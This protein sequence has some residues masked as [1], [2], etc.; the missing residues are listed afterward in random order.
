[1]KRLVRLEYFFVA[2]IRCIP[3]LWLWKYFYAKLDDETTSANDVCEAKPAKIQ[4]FW[5]FGTQIW[6]VQKS[7]VLFTK[8][9]FVEFTAIVKQETINAR[10]I[11]QMYQI[12]GMIG[13]LI[14]WKFYYLV[15]WKKGG[16]KNALFCKY[17]VK[18]VTV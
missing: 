4:L 6:S 3:P 1:M 9:K 17:L 7:L 11:F 2:S 14:I 12:E 10:N 13:I 8:I 16:M 15:L 5:I 18:Y